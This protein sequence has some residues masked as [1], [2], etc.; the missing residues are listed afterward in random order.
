MEPIEPA[1][2]MAS[3]RRPPPGAAARGD[4]RDRSGA[5]SFVRLEYVPAAF[6]VTRGQEHTLVYA[7]AAFRH[8]TSAADASALGRPITDV[9]TGRD[10]SALRAVLDRCWR[11]STVARDRRIEPVDTEL[12]VWYCT[13]WPDT[14]RDGRQGHLIVELREA[15]A[16]EL[17]LAMQREVA[18]RLLLS[19]LFERDL[20]DTA[21]ASNQRATFLAT[22]GRRLAGSLDEQTTLAEIAKLALPSLGAWCVVDLMD[23]ADGMRRLAI[24]HPDP[25]KQARL[26]EL[27]GR[28]SPKPGDPFGA[29]AVLR[30]RQPAVVADDIDEA[31][32]RAAHDPETLRILR[33]VGIGPL[34]T[35]PLVVR[36][37]LVGAL[38]FVGAARDHAYTPDDVALAE[39]LAIRSAMA[40]DSAR[41]HGEAIALRSAAETA[42]HAKTAF[43]GTMSHELRTPLNAISGYVDLI[44]M[45]LRGPVT[46]AQHADLARIRHNQ[47]HLLALITDVLNFVRV[48]N[49][50]V[51]YDMADVVM[52][53]VLANGVALVEPLIRQ[54]PLGFDG[55]AC[56]AA[57]VAR[58]DP[59][60]VTQILVNL[61]ANAIKFTPPGG[62]LGIACEVTAD[63]V[64][65]RIMDTGV[66]I[67]TDKLESIFE[68]F[69]QVRSG[70]AGRD[71][72]VGLGL[73]ISRD[74]ARGMG[75]DLSVESEPGAGS[76][77]TLS[78]EL[79]PT[80]R[81]RGAGR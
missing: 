28:W 68:P 49:G 81:A 61:L 66:G 57:I 65:V 31:L 47:Q 13:A 18:E 8:L 71:H 22:E 5:D 23:P 72:G 35:V 24:I 37:Q 73:S 26:R 2:A 17:T 62:R 76:T 33:E 45:G 3:Q 14:G 19:A 16:G 15:S 1:A 12:P 56:D 43:L 50:R 46:E 9:I 51:L 77:F 64:L 11:T 4:D 78:L 59:E 48:G 79:P 41:L 70:L 63:A 40:L 55:I 39:D 27:E 21:E 58:A 44:D 38:T 32:E 52:K 69:I 34:L 7:N 74:L 20:A 67:P 42:S 30:T 60:R 29:P 54:R 36:D 80:D 25:V 53:D 6:A 10:T 75:G